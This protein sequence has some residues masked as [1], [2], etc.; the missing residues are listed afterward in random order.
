MS[1]VRTFEYQEEDGFPITRGD[2]TYMVYGSAEADYSYSYAP[3]R[4]Y[5]PNGDPGYPDEENLDRTAF[6]CVVE[7]ICDEEGNPV[8]VKLTKEENDAFEVYIQERFDEIVQDA[9]WDDEA[10][11]R[12]EQ[13]WED[14]MLME[15][16]I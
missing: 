14:S 16:E 10:D 9:D 11:A 3:G 2:I 4:M 15:E 13:E 6:N 12:A 5:M 1:I 8:D 7:S